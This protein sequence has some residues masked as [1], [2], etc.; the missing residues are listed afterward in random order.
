MRSFGIRFPNARRFIVYFNG[1]VDI[2]S[3]AESDEW[4]KF[5]CKSLVAVLDDHHA[6]HAVN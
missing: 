1:L 6:V 5:S 4:E 3:V 2:P